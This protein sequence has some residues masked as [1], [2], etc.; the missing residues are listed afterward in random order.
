MYFQLRSGS[1]LEGI[2]FMEYGLDQAAAKK[3]ENAIA[4]VFLLI[5]AVTFFRSGKV[6]IMIIV[7]LFLFMAVLIQRQ[8]GSP[9]TD[10][11]VF[12]H[13]A[14]V[15]AP[16]GLFLLVKKDFHTR[17]IIYFILVLGLGITFITHGM[18]AVSLHPYFLDYLITSFQ[19]LAGVELDQHHAE[20]ILQIIGSLDILLGVF[21]FFVRNKWLLLWMAF[22]GLVTASSRITELGWG[23]YPEVLS[24][25]AHFGIPLTLIFLDR[26]IKKE[27]EERVR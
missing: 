21:I 27:T 12:A 4:L 6:L 19:N 10:C 13:A 14:R 23:M 15:L 25:A 18:E 22:W 16:L 11:T 3:I 8:A 17:K 5:G 26:C 2:L 24:R 1:A 20:R 7:F 9:F